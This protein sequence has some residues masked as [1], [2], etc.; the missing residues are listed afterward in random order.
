MSNA[1]IKVLEDE[2]KFYNSISNDDWSSDKNEGFKLGIKYC[3]DLIKK[4]KKES[5]L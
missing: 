5:T 1:I 3:K 4:L 2:V